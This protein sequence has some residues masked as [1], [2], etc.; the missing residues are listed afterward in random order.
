MAKTL[1]KKSNSAVQKK[2]AKKTQNK[3]T[4]KPALKTEKKTKKTAVSPKPSPKAIKSKAPPKQLTK[5]P[6]QMTQPSGPKKESAAPIPSKPL[7]QPQILKPSA[8]KSRGRKKQATHISFELSDLGTINRSLLNDEQ[9]KW[10]DL[11]EKNKKAPAVEYSARETFLAKTP[12]L[13]SVFGWGYIL[14]NEYDR[15]EVLFK[16]GKK[17]LI[18]NRKL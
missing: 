16:D 7:A 17:L 9:K 3:S 14:S 4:V 15:L 6:D 1:V 11:Y 5:K 8:P 18:S 10:L 12:L 2:T 13:H